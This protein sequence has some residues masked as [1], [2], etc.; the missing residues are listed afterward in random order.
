[1]TTAAQVR[2]G[3]VLQSYR[4]FASAGYDELL[5]SDGNSR[6]HWQPLLAALDAMPH[7]EQMTSARRIERRVWETG[8]AYDVFAD[9]TKATPGWQLDLM[10]VMISTVEWRWLAAALTQRARLFDAI[11]ADTYGD[12]TLMR[13]G[14]V[15]PELVF[16]DHAYLRS[17]RGVLPIAAPS[18]DYAGWLPFYAA[19][20]ARGAD[21]QWRVIDNHTETLAGV[22]VQGL[23][24]DAA[25]IVFPT[26]ACQPQ[27]TSRP[28]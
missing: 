14:L 23:Q 15:P 12:Q 24:W 21:G 19:D 27:R 18:R 7:A 8:I 17:C 6:P 10:P 25:S 4:P 9:P 22:A 1:M 20:L 2:S 11:L 26:V 3:A 13:R 5:A 28:R 16:A